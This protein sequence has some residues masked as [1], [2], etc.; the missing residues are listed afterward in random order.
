MG[1]GVRQQS[2]PLDA[3]PR[4]T[5]GEVMPCPICDQ[6]PMNCDCTPNRT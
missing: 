1:M 5:G 2:D 4:A 6:K 3:T